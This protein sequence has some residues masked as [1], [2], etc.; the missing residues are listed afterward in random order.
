MKHI[1]KKDGELKTSDGFEYSIKCVNTNE[2]SKFISDG[3]SKSLEEIE[4][5]PEKSVKKVAEKKSNAK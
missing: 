1:F 5:A 3:W 2:V 4:T